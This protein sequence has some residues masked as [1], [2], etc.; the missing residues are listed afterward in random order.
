MFTNDFTYVPDLI[1]ATEKLL[2]ANQSGIFNVTSWEDSSILNILQEVLHLPQFQNYDA[3]NENDPNIIF[4]LSPV[5]VHNFSNIDKLLQFYQPTHLHM[6]FINS[7]N[8][9]LKHQSS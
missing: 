8:A 7:Y 5:H 4:E 2:E 9:L 3:H 6:A 1:C